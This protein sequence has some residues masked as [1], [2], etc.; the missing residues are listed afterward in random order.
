MNKCPILFAIIHLSLCPVLENS[1]REFGRLGREVAKPVLRP[2]LSHIFTILRAEA[3]RRPGTFR[4]NNHQEKSNQSLARA[5][6]SHRLHSPE[7]NQSETELA[8]RQQNQ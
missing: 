3:A 7:D 4:G 1:S 2:W 6:F 5:A 8:S